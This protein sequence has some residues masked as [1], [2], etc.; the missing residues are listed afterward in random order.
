MDQLQYAVYHMLLQ[1]HTK[2]FKFFQSYLNL[3]YTFQFKNTGINA[4][5]GRGKTGR[6]KSSISNNKCYMLSVIY[7]LFKYYFKITNS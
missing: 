4:V 7:R 6:Y 2:D 1:H 3:K 5:L